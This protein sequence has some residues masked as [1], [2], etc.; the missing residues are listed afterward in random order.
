MNIA[1]H[2]AKDN[3]EVKVEERT[4]LLQKTLTDLEAEKQRFQDVLNMI[5]AFVALITPDYHVKF[6][7]KIYQ[8]SFG[9]PLDKE[10]YDHLFG[11][12]YVCANCKIKEVL[13]TRKPCYR[14]WTGPNGRIYHKSNFL[15]TDID[16]TPFILE[17]GVDITEKKNMEKLM[18]SKILETEENDRR[19]F[20]SDLHDDLGPTLSAIK[21][22]MNLLSTEKAH[23]ERT[24]LLNISDELL[25]ETI[26]KVR[27]LANNLMP[28]LIASYG[29]ETAVRSFIDKME[30]TCKIKFRFQ[31]N[32]ADY[33]F[34]AESELHL[35]RIITELVNNTI[36]HSGANE[37][38]LELNLSDQTLKIVYSDNGKGYNFQKDLSE[39]TGI[40]LHNIMNRATLVNGTIDFLK[41]A[42]KIVVTINKPLTDKISLKQ[43]PS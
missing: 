27:T 22:Q 43:L 30:K 36:K 42:G 12:T 11:R 15:F 8:E 39:A 19:R 38:I 37:V 20:A 4:S 32:L 16:G 18:L 25:S 5:P 40:G 35:Y 13:K 6:S 21:L 2:R 33:R 17:M 14:E 1:L 24:E 26:E 23:K 29:L 3:L 31:S 41:K 34:E 7:N 9:K 10:C 28:R